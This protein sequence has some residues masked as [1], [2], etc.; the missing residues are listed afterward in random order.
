[1]DVLFVLSDIYHLITWPEDVAVFSALNDEDF[2]DG[3]GV[4]R[5]GA[6]ALLG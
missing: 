3:N 1:M 4:W 5:C 6:V 2:V